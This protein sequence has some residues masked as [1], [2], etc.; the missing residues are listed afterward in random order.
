MHLSGKPLTGQCAAIV[1]IEWWDAGK[2]QI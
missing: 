1:N 2:V